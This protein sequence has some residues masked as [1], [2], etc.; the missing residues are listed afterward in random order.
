MPT[1]GMFMLAWLSVAMIAA[2]PVS[3]EQFQWAAFLVAQ[4]SCFAAAAL[5]AGSAESGVP[6]TADALRLRSAAAAVSI[7]YFIARAAL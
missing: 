4:V 1:P 2:H 3:G 6:M 5:E 7:A